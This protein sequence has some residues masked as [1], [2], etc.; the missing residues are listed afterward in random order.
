MK[1]LLI[2]IVILFLGS[3]FGFGD[4]IDTATSTT[5]TVTNVGNSVVDSTTSIFT[6]AINGIIN[7]ANDA[8][9]KTTSAATGAISTLKETANQAVSETQKAVAGALD[10][11]KDLP[12]T[13]LNTLMSLSDEMCEKECVPFYNIPCFV[14]FGCKQKL[15]F[16][17]LI[18]VLCVGGLVL[19]CCL[20]STGI[21]NILCILKVL[22]MVTGIYPLF[23]LVKYCCM[24]KKD[25]KDKEQET[26]DPK[27]TTRMKN[28]QT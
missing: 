15:K 25:E 20:M 5:S 8:V 6:D 17:G 22:G 18:V 9:S 4:I 3:C 12:N 10:A 24:K 14:I 28:I 27:T 13:L 21:I 16:F 23:K 2:F 26:D 11:V 1:K 19:L 7:A